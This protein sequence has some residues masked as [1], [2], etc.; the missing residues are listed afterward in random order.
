MEK[1]APGSSGFYRF[2]L[3]NTLSRELKLTLDISE[4]EI[5]LPLQITLTPLKANGSKLTKQAVSGSITDGKLTLQD[6]IGANE[7]ITY[8]LDWEWPF[9]G[10]DT[11][12]TAIGEAGGIY[13][14]QL[15]I[16]AEEN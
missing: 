10:N 16:H 4:G 5:H 14:L 15:L 7:L 3:K 6:E 8:Q 9:T 12:D 11:A 2:Q 1:V 13:T